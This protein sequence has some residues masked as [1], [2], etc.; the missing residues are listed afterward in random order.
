[1]QTRKNAT[2]RLGMIG[3]GRMGLGDMEGIMTVGLREG[4]EARVVAVCDVDQNRLRF[5]KEKVQEFYRSQGEEKVSVDVY[6]DYRDLLARKDIDAVL[7]STPER[8]HALIGIAAAKA[9]KHIFLQKP[10][11]Y[12]IP[13]G[14]ALVKAVRANNVVLQTGS[15]QRSSVYFHQVCTIVRNNWLGKLMSIEVEIPTDKGNAFA[16]ESAVPSALDYDMWLGPCEMTPYIEEGVHPQEG[17]GRPG[18]LQRQDYCLGMITGWGSHMYDIAQWGMGV[19]RDSGPVEIAAKGDFPDRGVFDVHVGYEGEALYENGVRLLSRNGSAGVKFIMEDGW[20]YCS[21]GSFDCSDKTLLRRKT[22][23]GDVEL[24]RSKNHKSDFIESA[25]NGSD[26]VCPVEVGHRSNSVCVLHHV[27]MK[28]GGK[29]VH[30]DPKN[31]V[32]VG[33]QD[34]TNLINVPMKEPWTIS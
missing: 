24:Y 3:T 7:I 10:L 19:D 1:M 5:A 30:W 6:S 18:W 26:P 16:K 14:Q 21:R 12:S 20:A 8:W 2:M 15:Q 17:F 25:L 23:Q 9:G 11:T 31:E 32:A 29:K 4:T 27:S 34:A 22:V 33:D 28:L 13:E